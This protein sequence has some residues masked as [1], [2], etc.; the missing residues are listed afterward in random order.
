VATPSTPAADGRSRS[1]KHLY[2]HHAA[3]EARELAGLISERLAE[4]PEPLSAGGNSAPA[5]LDGR[6]RPLTRAEA[7]TFVQSRFAERMKADLR[8]A[9]LH[10][11]FYAASNLLAVAG[12]SASAAI[13]AT[14]GAHSLAV[15]LIGLAVATSAALSQLFRFGERSRVRYRAGNQLR[16]EGWDYVIGRGRYRETQ[17]PVEAFGRFY[18]VFWEIEAPVDRSV[19]HREGSHV[20]GVLADGDSAELPRS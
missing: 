3:F 4:L 19:E 13:A 1:K 20:D 12:G 6:R 5:E 7:E 10:S 15:L 9:P 8:T 2:R 16:K 18:D 11:F 14:S 17:D